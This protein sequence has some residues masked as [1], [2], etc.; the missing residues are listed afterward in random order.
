MQT[1]TLTI[2]LSTSLIT[3]CSPGQTLKLGAAYI[4]HGVC[5][6]AFVSQV[7]PDR[8][9]R[10]GVGRTGPIPWLE[11]GVRYEID[12]A[13]RQVRTTFLGGYAQTSAYHEGEGCQNRPVGDDERARFEREGR[14][15]S[16]PS[17]ASTALPLDVMIARDLPLR[18]AVDAFFAPTPSGDGERTNAVVVMQDGRV[19]AERY[20]LGYGPDTLLP[21]YSDTKS[22]VSALIGVL[23]RQGKLRVE[24]RAPIA[25]WSGPKDPRRAITIDDLLR[26]KSGLE[27]DEDLAGTAD[28]GARIWFLEPDQ[29]ALPIS[30]PLAHEPG[31]AW[32]YSSGN[33]AVL[34]RVLRDATGGTKEGFLA[35]A[36][37]E[38]FEPLGLERVELEL[39]R[40]G[41]P[42]G[43]SGMAATARDWARFGALYAQDGVIGSE[44]ILPEGWVDYSASPTPNAW[45]G[46]GA[47]FWTNRGDSF[48]ARRRRGWG[49]SPRSFFASGHMGQIVLIVP[50][51]HLVIARFG[52]SHGRY[53][54]F[55]E[56]FPRLAALTNAVRALAE[57]TERADLARLQTP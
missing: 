49:I 20:G 8:A 40:T 39:D 35:F 4:S 9:Y 15:A 48:G 43:G 29:A 3:A 53:G 19:I 7:D 23:V 55:E 32:Q 51:Q 52:W 12:A 46:Y 47:G 24:D 6:A 14:V 38:L 42:S 34:S 13:R 30:R 37:R 17:A 44:R 45:V 11:P 57:Q 31:S 2:A 33:T 56:L 18:R 5:T 36:R 25:A 54:G 41:T 50:E 22:V 10:E 28:D 1:S 16:A 26:M 27:W 21:G